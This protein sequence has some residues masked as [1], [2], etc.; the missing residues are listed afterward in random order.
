MVVRVSRPE[1]AKVNRRAVLDAAR[2]VFLRSGY[3]AATLDTVAAQAGFTIGA[4][5]SR[6]AGKADLFLA[7]LEQR[8]DERIEQIR[9]LPRRPTS[10]ARSAVGSRQWASIL[11]SD[12]NWTLLVVEFRVHAARDAELSRRYAGLHQRLLDAVAEQI[13]DGASETERERALTVARALLA[14]GAGSALARAAEGDAFSDQLVE[15]VGV[16]I[17]NHFSGT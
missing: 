10:A 8:I 7:L 15:Q 14:L 5:Y 3:H 13:G 2:T 17:T 16:A 12:L 9:T 1:Q 6:F 11:A 4:I